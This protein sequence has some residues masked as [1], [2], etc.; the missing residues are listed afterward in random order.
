MI[1]YYDRA[2][3]YALKSMHMQVIIIIT[4]CLINQLQMRSTMSALR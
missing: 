1:Y 2:S 3:T 4:S